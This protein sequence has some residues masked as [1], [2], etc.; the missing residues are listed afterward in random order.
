MKHLLTC[1]DLTLAG[2]GSVHILTITII[3]NQENMSYSIL[4]WR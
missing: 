1:Q 3:H 2:E 4:G